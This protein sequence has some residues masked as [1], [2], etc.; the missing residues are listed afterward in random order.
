MSTAAT[1]LPHRRFRKL[2]L[3][4]ALFVLVALVALVVLLLTLDA[5]VYRPRLER[6]ISQALGRE[7]STGD[8]SYY[9]S[10]R[11]T[12]SVRDLR[13]AKCGRGRRGRTGAGSGGAI[14]RGLIPWTAGAHRT[15]RDDQGERARHLRGTAE[16]R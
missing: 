14:R 9:L 3:W 4:A 5:N 10:L 11:P 16:S 6:E 8:L 7:V 15:A 12:F 1:T 13:I 2:L